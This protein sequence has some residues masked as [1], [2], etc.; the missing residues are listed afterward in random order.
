MKI[1]FL[2]KFSE[3]E[4][5]LIKLAEGIGAQIDAEIDL[6][7]VVNSYP[8]IPLKID[9]AVIDNCVDFDLSDLFKEKEKE[10]VIAQE[11]KNTHSIVKNVEV[12]VGNLERIVKHKLKE[13]NYDLILMGS[14]K[15]SLIEDLTHES[16]VERISD[17]SDLPVLTVKSVN[18]IAPTIEN[19]GVFDDFKSNKVKKLHVL[20]TLINKVQPTVHLYKIVNHKVEDREIKEGEAI[21]SKFAE[22]NEI[23]KYEMHVLSLDKKENEEGV[24]VKAIENEN[25][26][27]VAI[28]ELHRYKFSW[29]LSKSLKSSVADHVP[30]PLLIY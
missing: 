26:Q 22:E 16:T 3:V 23:V 2:T 29:L 4:E 18:L 24:I 28:S 21:M 15:T 27:L 30:S 7:H 25:L 11:F 9:G 14:H 6:L 17:L 5:Y 10:E 8:Q 12:L 20:S 19:I 1:L 13:C